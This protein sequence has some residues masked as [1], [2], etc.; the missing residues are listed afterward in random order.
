MRRLLL[1]F[2]FALP[3]AFLLAAEPA[4]TAQDILEGV[5]F[6]QVQQQIDLRGELRQDKIRVPFQL[7]QSGP[8]V[9]YIFFDPNET[10]QL[11]IGEKESRLE[12]VSESGA[13]RV[14]PADFDH[15]VRG[16]DLTYEDLSLKFLYWPN[17]EVLGSENIRTRN[18]WKLLLRSPGKQ[19]Q[20]AQVLL[21]VDKNGGA[22]MRLEA[23]DAAGRL[24]KRF[25]VVS[26]QKI[27]D[28]WFLKEMRIEEVQPG[29]NHVLS[30]TYL[31]IKK[32]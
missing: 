31:N 16:T 19:S 25:E 3:P 10:L 9:R 27:E 14:K 12:E 5:R 11:Q 6:R 18:C 13:E 7:V 1:L 2:A 8:T 22:L 26:A 21:W 17:P 30:R 15:K 20:Y 23:Y 28:R 24:L 32:S 29:T 4:P